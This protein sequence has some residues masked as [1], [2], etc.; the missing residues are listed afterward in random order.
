MVKVAP[1]SV[2]YYLIGILILFSQLLNR[3]AWLALLPFNIPCQFLVPVCKS[4]GLFKVNPKFFKAEPKA[5]LVKYLTQS[6]DTKVNHNLLKV[7]VSR[8]VYG[9]VRQYQYQSIHLNKH[10]SI[11]SPAWFILHVS[12]RIAIIRNEQCMNH[13]NN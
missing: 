2:W 9:C 13:V 3:I 7:C 11:E 10:F 12:A 8:N 6:V 1:L 5:C 4:K